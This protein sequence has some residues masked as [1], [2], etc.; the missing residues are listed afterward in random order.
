MPYGI[1]HTPAWAYFI[2][3]SDRSGCAV[4]VR[5][6]GGAKVSRTRALDKR[7]YGGGAV[8]GVRL[9]MQGEVI[10]RRFRGTP[11]VG[12]AAVRLKLRFQDAPVSRCETDFAMQNH[13]EPTPPSEKE[14]LAGGEDFGLSRAGNAL[15]VL[16]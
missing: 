11:S 4:G 10:E 9:A 13:L 15:K 12:S 16:S 2:E 3:R 7:P 1:F 8:G 6:R 5:L 14:A